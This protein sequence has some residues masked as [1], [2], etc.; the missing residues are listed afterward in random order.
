MLQVAGPANLGDKLRD[1]RNDFILGE[2]AIK[3]NDA[4]YAA[5]LRNALAYSGAG[6]PFL[7]LST[8]L[9][10]VEISLSR[11]SFASASTA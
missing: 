3:R 1:A 10:W 2:L 11:I 4:L 8:S 5:R 6:R 9:T 7:W